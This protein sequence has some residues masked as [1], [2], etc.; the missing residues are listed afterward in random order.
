M[1]A[2]E[3]DTQLHPRDWYTKRYGAWIYLDMKRWE[4]KDYRNEAMEWDDYKKLKTLHWVCKFKQ[5]TFERLA[6]IKAA[7]DAKKETFLDVDGKTKALPPEDKTHEKQAMLVWKAGHDRTLKKRDEDGAFTGEEE[8]VHLDAYK[9]I[10]PDIFKLWE[11]QKK[12]QHTPSPED[13]E[14]RKVFRKT[15]AERRK[16]RKAQEEAEKAAAQT[17]DPMTLFQKRDDAQEY[18]KPKVRYAQAQP[19]IL[20]RL[21]MI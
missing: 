5:K 21:S 8:T 16:Q 15:L 9:E 10:F 18:G 4:T 3:P 13:A 17:V 19:T 12:M 20:Q 2:G 14:K 7:R 1:Q 6:K 11:A